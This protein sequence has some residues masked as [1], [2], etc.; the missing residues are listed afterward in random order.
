MVTMDVDLWM[1]FNFLYISL[2]STKLYKICKLFYILKKINL[3]LM[4]II[5]S[6]QCV[7]ENFL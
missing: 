7:S 1:I 6:C 2:K 3:F 4:F 5:L